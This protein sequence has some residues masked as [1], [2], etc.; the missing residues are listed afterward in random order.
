MTLYNL[1][2][3]DPGVCLNVIDILG[4]VGQ[5]LSLV[6]EKLDESMRRGVFLLRRQNVLGDGE[7]D[8][9]VLPED[10]NIK[11]FLRVA[12]TQVLQF[13]IETGVF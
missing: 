5:Q 12:Q 1:F 11:N 10:M 3:E 2:W 6:L 8:A 4:V 9:G 13:R 7:E